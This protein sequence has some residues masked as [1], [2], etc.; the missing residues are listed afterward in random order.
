MPL[1][2]AFLSTAY[3]TQKWVNNK[4]RGKAKG[5]GMAKHYITFESRKLLLLFLLWINKD[6]IK[7]I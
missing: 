3:R 2:N 7:L 5:S 4:P 1:K 6:E